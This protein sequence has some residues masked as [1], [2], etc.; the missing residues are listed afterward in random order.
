MKG[1]NRLVVTSEVISHLGMSI[2]AILCLNSE[3]TVELGC[4]INI[5]HISTLYYIQ[6]Q[7]TILAPEHMG[8][9]SNLVVETALY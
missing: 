3:I 2:R 7:I 1:L 5:G 8:S 4:D 6:Q 9:Y